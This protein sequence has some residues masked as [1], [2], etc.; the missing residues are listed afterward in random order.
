MSEQ[1]KYRVIVSDRA[2]QLLVQ[3]AAFLAKVN[4]EA[5]DRLVETFAETANSLEEMPMRGAWFSA[6]YIP[7]NVYRYLVFEKRYLMLY[8][9]REYTVYVE[10]VLDCRQ[11]YRWLLHS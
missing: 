2:A 3:H 9:V 1:A 4:R 11:D 8:Q 5:A 7:R 10:Y 6:N